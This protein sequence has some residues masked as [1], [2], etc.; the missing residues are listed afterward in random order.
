MFSVGYMQCVEVIFSV[1]YILVCPGVFVIYLAEYCFII[2]NVPITIGI[3][4]GFRLLEMPLFPH[5]RILK[6][7]PFLL[8]KH[9][10]IIGLI[11]FSI[12]I[13]CHILLVCVLSHFRRHFMLCTYTIFLLLVF[14]SLEYI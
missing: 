1:L 3:V 5:I 6:F 7:S 12:S 11:L 8:V 14:H 13:Y 10:K 2:H 4:S 9:I